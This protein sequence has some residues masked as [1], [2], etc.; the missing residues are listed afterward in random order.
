MKLY[1][2]QHVLTWGDAYEICLADDVDE[3]AVLA[4]V[5]VIDARI[6]AERS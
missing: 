5:L 6:E 4:V 2:K 3:V 1:M